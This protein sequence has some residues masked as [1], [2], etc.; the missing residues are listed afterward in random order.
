MTTNNS[1]DI[2]FP[3]SVPQGGTGVTSLSTYSVLTGGTTSTGAIQT[4]ASVGTIGQILLSNGASVLPTMQNNNG[5]LTIWA[6]ASS[7]TAMVSGNGYINTNISSQ[8]TFT[9][10]AI[11]ALGDWYEICGTFVSI[12][13]KITY[14]SGQQ[15]DTSTIT[16]G[17]VS[18]TK[19]IAIK[20]V[21]ITA[22]TFFRIVSFSVYPTVV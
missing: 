20:I 21:C 9:L 18:G 12:G 16:T 22:N 2:T 11:A 7:G 4:I 1:V 15:I 17:N 14:N 19:G 6:A 13:W 5:G 8:Q 3:I 10:P